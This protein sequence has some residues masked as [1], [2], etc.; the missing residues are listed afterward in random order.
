MQQSTTLPSAKISVVAQMWTVIEVCTLMG[1]HPYTVTT[2]EFKH[3][4]DTESGWKSQKKLSQARCGFSFLARFGSSSV[5]EADRLTLKFPHFCGPPT[6]NATYQVIFQ[7]PVEDRLAVPETA[8]GSSRP[9]G[10]RFPLCEYAFFLLMV[11]V[12]QGKNLRILN[13]SLQRADLKTSDWWGRNRQKSFTVGSSKLTMPRAGQPDSNVSVSKMLETI[14][15]EVFKLLAGVHCMNTGERSQDCLY[16]TA[17]NWYFSL[18]GG[19][20]IHLMSIALLALTEDISVDDLLNSLTELGGDVY[21][22]LANWRVKTYNRKKG[23]KKPEKEGLHFV[24][25]P[26]HLQDERVGF[27]DLTRVLVYCLMLLT[28]LRGFVS[29][30]I[31][32]DWVA[33]K[34]KDANGALQFVPDPEPLK[35]GTDR[36][37]FN[38]LKVSETE[39]EW[40]SH[41]VQ[42]LFVDYNTTVDPNDATVSYTPHFTGYSARNA[43]AHSNKDAGVPDATTASITSHTVATLVKHYQEKEKVNLK[44]TRGIPIEVRMH[45]TKPGNQAFINGF[46]YYCNL[47]DCTNP[48]NFHGARLKEAMKGALGMRGFE[49]LLAIEQQL[50]EKGLYQ[51]EQLDHLKSGHSRVT[52]A[53]PAP[54]F[55][56]GEGNLFPHLSELT[57]DELFR[58]L[59]RFDVSGI[60]W[61]GLYWTRP[62]MP[63]HWANKAAELHSMQAS[64]LP[65][66]IAST[67]HGTWQYDHFVQVSIGRTVPHSQWDA[68]RHPLNADVAMVK[69]QAEAQAETIAAQQAHLASQQALLDAQ[70]RESAAQRAQLASQQA[71]ID[72]MMTM[73]QKQQAQ[74][75]AAPAPLALPAP[76]ASA[77]LPAPQT[78]F[79]EA[80]A[81]AQQEPPMSEQALIT[82]VQNHM[83]AGGNAALY[84]ILPAEPVLQGQPG[85]Q[86]ETNLEGQPPCKR[87]RRPMVQ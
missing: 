43:T 62:A 14:T 85:P 19:Q 71:Q 68:R 40:V 64:P 36:V 3:W 23:K 52:K 53:D 38:H 69:E 9:Q 61:G 28:F 31:L 5:L 58:K 59:P 51:A 49:M 46:D 18:E 12:D 82:Y 65:S 48:Q 37:V 11:L 70:Q 67:S 34:R 77:P 39:V 7:N 78:T 1:K 63:K 4:F 83:A 86:G 79:T 8:T 32:T 50:A 30:R 54:I 25:R 84:V 6:G 44:D 17:D 35:E 27:L 55:V 21:L 74:V 13:Q 56:G 72:M 73:M 15:G 80:A 29:H 22:T 66:A 75:Q 2:E 10:V 41:S 57:L 81:V 16:Y 76:P 42:G 26:V 87:Q 60:S 45:G 33:N 24:P 20:R 47:P